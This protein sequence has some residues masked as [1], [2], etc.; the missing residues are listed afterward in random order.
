MTLTSPAF[1][2]Q[3]LIPAAY[4]CDG[5][6]T[7]P[8]L[9]I[10]DVPQSAVTLA[11]IMEDPDV[12][13]SIRSDGMW[14]HWIVWNIPPT[15]KEVQEGQGIPGAVVGFNSGGEPEY[16]APCPPDR[17]HRYFFKLYALDT[18]LSLPVGST[19]DALVKAMEGHIISATECIGRYERHSL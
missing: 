17:E 12:P 4:T 18:I 2:N 16:Y 10:S 15:I 9:T 14:D 1:A 13:K 3:Q 7:Q 11:L 19:K 5:A 6:S 8:P